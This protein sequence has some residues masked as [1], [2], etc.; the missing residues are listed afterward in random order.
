M[1]VDAEISS[2]G[3]NAGSKLIR[4]E[5]FFSIHRSPP[6]PPWVAS[7]WRGDVRGLRLYGASPA[8]WDV[9]T[10]NGGVQVRKGQGHCAGRRFPCVERC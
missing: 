5:G 9:Q 2:N 1:N 3:C 8:M 6:A 4:G 7:M 10:V